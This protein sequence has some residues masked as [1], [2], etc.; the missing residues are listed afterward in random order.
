M[1]SIISGEQGPHMAGAT[2][3]TATGPVS[4]GGL[5]RREKKIL[6]IKTNR[7]IEKDYDEDN[8]I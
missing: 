5:S 4:P 3:A 6:T 8:Q 1:R 2:D 7:I